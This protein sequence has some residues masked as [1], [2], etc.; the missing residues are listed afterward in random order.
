MRRLST[1]GHTSAMLIRQARQVIMLVYDRLGAR[2]RSIIEIRRL[3]LG[4]P[5]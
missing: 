2:F 1:D 5:D 4:L 3:Q